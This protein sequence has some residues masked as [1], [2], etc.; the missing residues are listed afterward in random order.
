[1]LHCSKLD[2]GYLTSRARYSRR[3]QVQYSRRGFQPLVLEN[4]IR[5]PPGAVAAI[6]RR[7][8]ISLS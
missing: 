7:V 3:A 1:M 6:E 4:H 8:N 5:L 2:V